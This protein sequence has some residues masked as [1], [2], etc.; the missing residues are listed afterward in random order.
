MQYYLVKDLKRIGKVDNGVPY[1]HTEN[2]W[3]V[4]NSNILMDRIM[5]YDGD[6][7]GCISMLSRVEE[8][9]EEAALTAIQNQQ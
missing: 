9:S 7:I 6:S 4:D 2:G 5:G 8:I 1:L 3:V